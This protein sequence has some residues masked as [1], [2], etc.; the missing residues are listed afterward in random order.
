M[1]TR[2]GDIDPAIPLFLQRQAGMSARRVEKLLEQESGL[3]GL[4]GLRDMRDILGAAGH[5]VAGWPM[6]RWTTV[7]RDHARVA[8]DLYFHDIRKYLSMYLGLLP[9]AQVIVFTGSIGQNSWIRQQ[10]LHGVPAAGRRRL[11]IPTDEEQAIA[12]ELQPMIH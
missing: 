1:S 2:S 3:F 5:P 9:T 7:E 8:L 11:V 12:D 4:T 6:K 10:V